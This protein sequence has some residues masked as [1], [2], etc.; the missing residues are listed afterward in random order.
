MNRRLGAESI[1]GI[2]GGMRCDSINL[3]PFIGLFD[4]RSLTIAEGLCRKRK[5]LD[6]IPYL[7]KVMEDPNN[8][9]ADIQFCFLQPNLTMSM[10]VLEHAEQKAMVRIAFEKGDYNKS[11]NTVIEML[12]LCPGDNMGQRSELL[13]TGALAAFRLWGGDSLLARQYLRLG[14]QNNPAILMR[15]LGKEAHDYRWLTQ[16]LWEAQDAWTWADG[17]EA[18]GSVLKSCSRQ[19]CTRRE[20][21]LREFKRCSGCKQ[22]VYC[23]S[24]CQKDDWR[25]HKPACKAH[26]EQMVIRRAM[27]F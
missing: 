13:Y 7:T 20:G 16:N 5:P 19:G 1:A 26:K 4:T 3:S 23:S 18:K 6:A 22:T 14:A 12:R 10:Q 21:R 2:G 25:S 27:A 8:L 11:A 17:D 24:E 15:L 9:D